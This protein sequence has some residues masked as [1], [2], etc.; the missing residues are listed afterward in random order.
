MVDTG[1]VTYEYGLSNKELFFTGLSNNTGAILAV[2]AAIASIFGV[3][4]NVL[5]TGLGRYIYNE[6]VALA[7]SAF[8]DQLI[9]FVVGSI[10]AFMAVI[11]LFSIVGTCISYGGFK[12]KRRGTRIEV[13]HGL[14]QHRFH[15]VDI[16]RVQSV[17][18]KQS[19]IRRLIGY[20]ELSLGKIDAVEASSK[21]SQEQAQ[22]QQGIIVHP[23]VKMSRVPEILAG[24]TPEFADVPT[25]QIALPKVSKRRALI[26]RVILHGVGFWLAIITAV[27]QILANNFGPINDPEFFTALSYFNMGAIGA[28][29]L[30]AIIMVL[31]IIGAL[32]WF[33]GSSFAYNRRFMQITNGGFSRASISFPRKKIQFGFTRSNPLQ[34]GSRVAT[35]NARTA[36]GVGGTTVRLLD[37]DEK[38]AEKWL[39]WVRPGQSVVE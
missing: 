12:A 21:D 11:W 2:S 20:C 17:I 1:V 14:L 33:K 38:E 13:E 6:G 5:E 31:N 25:E 26:R 4:S 39:D 32:M 22:L 35:I 10:I 24:L 28:Y 18:I 16:D 7:T 15:G 27:I 30:C 37:V 23:F 9:W 19:F 36:A 8:A 34:R 3:M 29:I